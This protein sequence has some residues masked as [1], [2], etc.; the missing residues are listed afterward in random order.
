VLIAGDNLALTFHL[1]NGTQ[2]S[3][4]G[5]TSICYSAKSER[6]ENSPTPISDNTCAISLLFSSEHLLS[7]WNYQHRKGEMISATLL[8]AG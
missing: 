6:V 7:A 4:S 3:S 2:M 1:Q 5:T 8:M